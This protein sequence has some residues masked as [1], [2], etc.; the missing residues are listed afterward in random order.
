MRAGKKWLLIV[1]VLVSLA[2]AICYWAYNLPSGEG[3]PPPR[4]TPGPAV[5]ATPQLLTLTEAVGPFVTKHPPLVPKPK[6]VTPANGR[7][8]SLSGWTIKAPDSPLI[9]EGVKQLRESLGA[10]RPGSPIIE[11]R[12][13]P[14]LP[15]AAEGYRLKAGPQQVL[16]QGKDE[17]GVFY[18]VQTLRQ[19]VVDGRLQP[20]SV[21]DWPSL[22]TRGLHWTGG[23]RSGPFHRQL[24]EKIAAPLKLNYILYETQFAQWESQPKIWDAKASTPLAELRATV[25][26]AHQLGMEVVP[27]V[28]MLTHCRWLFGNGQNED[29]AT[30][31]MHYAYD[32]A[33]PRTRQVVAGVLEEVLE[34]F[35][36]RTLHIGHDEPEKH[37]VAVWLEDVLFW[38]DWLAQ[39]QVKTM[40]WGDFLLAPKEGTPATN[41]ETVAEAQELR[42]KLPKDILVADWHYGDNNQVP[43]LQLFLKQGF[44][45]LGCSSSCEV[46]SENVLKFS[47]ECIAQKVGLV[48]TTWVGYDFSPDIIQGW[49]YR[50]MV[51]LVLAAEAAW[52][53]GAA[54]AYNA[55]EVFNWYW[56]GPP[57][58]VAVRPGFFV[59]LKE[60]DNASRW[61]WGQEQ[62]RLLPSPVVEQASQISPGQ[63]KLKSTHFLVDG[64]VLLA[65]P[66][67][68]KGT[69]PSQLQL[70]LGRK[71]AE[72]QFLWGTTRM[73][74]RADQVGTLSVVYAN[75]QVES[76]KL[77]YGKHIQCLTSEEPS[78]LTPLLWRGVLGEANVWLRRYAWKNPHPDW[79]IDSVNLASEGGVAAPILLGL[80]GVEP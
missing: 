1:S 47:Q 78:G 45:V 43:S 70:H 22:A 21:E 16:I 37:D 33:N 64:A 3:V 7:P 39:R 66:A 32:P 10:Q 2:A 13:E 4:S 12:V 67:N 68:P 56:H 71:A 19:L 42:S 40:V 73:V 61:L 49:E 17:H 18:G 27:L 29:L 38:H 59:S 48:H 69:W 30:N 25:E 77:L 23:A 74:T 36:P 44:Q 52:N 31:K 60:L 65:G 41:C 35:K 79:P 26:R 54:V 9:Q 46:F 11:L 80:T 34:I 8:F 58:D 14:N 20:V 28:Q 72:L 55:E 15:L 5:R 24:L 51:S 6:K 57:A 50:Q 76:V 62:E 75:G 63:H 53:G